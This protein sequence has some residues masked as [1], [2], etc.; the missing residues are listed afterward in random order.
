MAPAITV[1]G[2]CMRKYFDLYWAFIFISYGL[3]PMLDQV[4]SEDWKNPTL[5][6]IIELE[7]DQRYRMVIYFMVAL[8]VFIFSS[9]VGNIGE[10]TFFNAL[11]RLFVLANSYALG[12]IISHELTHKENFLDRAVGSL[13]LIKNCYM[14]YTIDHIYGHHKRV[15]TP[16]DPSSAPR[17]ITLYQFVRKTV[18]NTFLSA[19]EMYPKLVVL[20][21]IASFAFVMVLYK[22]YG[23]KVVLIHLF[24]AAGS[25]QLLETANY[26]EHYGLQRKKLADGTYEK[27][28]IRHSWNAAHRI[29]NLF[30]L[31]LQ[32]HSDHHENSLKPYQTLSTYEDS[33]QLPHGYLVC[34][35]IAHFPNVAVDVILDLVRHDAPTAGRVQLQAKRKGH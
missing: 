13:I 2:F 22:L 4:L 28:T 20:G 10:F 24:A 7:R 21:T 8:D 27:V 31:K 34:V 1:F 6:Q 12:I 15:S 11:P 29:S 18:K 19:Y 26:M 3:I 17:G 25:I 16:E 9:E 30:F 23:W 33:P 35:I 14:H 32:R 5:K